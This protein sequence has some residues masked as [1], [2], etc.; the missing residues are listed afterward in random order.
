MFEYLEEIDRALLLAINGFHHP[1]AD[2]FMWHASRKWHWLPVYLILL[3]FAVKK[4]KFQLWKIA[5]GVA[6]LIALTDQI[7]VKLFKEV[8]ERY[9]PCHNLELKEVIHLL[10]NKCGGKYGFISS[11]AS[12][13]FGICSFLGMMLNKKGSLKAFYLMLFWAAFISYSRIYMGVHYPSD[14]LAGAALGLILGLSMYRMF[15]KYRFINDVDI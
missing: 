6:V 5:L 4:Y 7:S 9:R 8:I 11:H 15:K 14:I 13:Y 3:Y 10:R 2:F 12:N 1:I